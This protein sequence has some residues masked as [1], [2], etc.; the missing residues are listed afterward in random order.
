MPSRL[1]PLGILSLIAFIWSAQGGL[2]QQLFIEGEVLVGNFKVAADAE[3]DVPVQI[4]IRKKPKLRANLPDKPKSYVTLISDERAK[5]FNGGFHT[6]LHTP[7]VGRE[8]AAFFCT[9][10]DDGTFNI[11][12]DLAVFERHDIGIVR[13]FKKTEL[14]LAE[15]KR[16]ATI[17]VSKVQKEAYAKEVATEVS[18]IQKELYAL[19]KKVQEPIKDIPLKSWGAKVGTALETAKLISTN[20]PLKTEGK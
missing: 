4:V 19:A 11:Y 16:Q 3:T 18:E 9:T 5:Q 1:L 14:R 6:M 13:V 2:A 20:S 12:I 15:W 17:N 7:F 8:E 10:N